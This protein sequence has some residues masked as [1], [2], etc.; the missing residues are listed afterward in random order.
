MSLSVSALAKLL[1]PTGQALLTTL[2]PYD[3]SQVLALANRLRDDGTDPELVAAT[4]TQS[5]LRTKARTKFGEFT[6][7]MLFTP[8]GVEQATRLQ[9]AALHAR[10][11][12]AAGCTHVADLTC[13]VGADSLALAGVGLRVTACELDEVTAAVA[14]HNLRPFP[15]AQVLHQDG[16]TLNFAALGIDGIYADPARR[17]GG[18]RVFDP[19]AYTP[20]LNAVWNLREQVSAVGI[21]VGPG[22]PHQGLP[23]DA[24]VQWVSVDGDV[25]E[26][27]FWFGP[28][29]PTGPGRTALIL[30]NEPGGLMSRLVTSS[31]MPSDVQLRRS[32]LSRPGG[33][34]HAPPVGPLGEYL[35]EP[36]GAVIR[37]GLIGVAAAELGGSLL[38]P[39]IAYITTDALPPASKGAPLATGY[40]VL[41]SLPFS[42]KRLKAYLRERNVGR[43]AIKKRGTAVTPEAL[44][45]QLALSGPNEATLVLTRI[46]GKQSVIVVEPL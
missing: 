18:R 15:E 42:V 3:E 16:L 32:S 40:R 13:G 29:A 23:P 25:V 46:A 26:A 44:R 2:P 5:R 4:L 10:R 22:I 21:K 38:D 27:G 7:Q 35:F 8:I 39:T 37:A 43:V 6:D 11:Y 19:A 30:R 14:T 20:P 17:T 34:N 9:V 36:D 24:E 28:L 12:L 31:S 1:S 45:P 33:D 41:D